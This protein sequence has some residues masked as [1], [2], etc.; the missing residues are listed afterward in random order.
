MPDSIGPLRWQFEVPHLGLADFRR[1][2]RLGL[3][4]HTRRSTSKS[5]AIAFAIGGAIG[6]LVVLAAAYS[7]IWMDSSMTVGIGRRR[8]LVLEDEAFWGVVL[9]VAVVMGLC[10][11][12]NYR[13]LVRRIY[14]TSRRKMPTWSLDVGEDGLHMVWN[15][16]TMTVPWSKLRNVQS[17]ATAT[18][19]TV[20]AYIP[21]VGVSHAGFAADAEREACLAF[22]AAKVPPAKS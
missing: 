5:F 21:A 15:E 20:D 1:L 3:R 16:V 13:M 8:L 17:T 11:A 18:F 14:D 12:V 10:T 7:D 19:L 2:Q 4:Q 9:A 6:A 22:I